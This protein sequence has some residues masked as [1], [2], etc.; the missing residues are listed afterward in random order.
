VLDDLFDDRGATICT[1]AIPGG[2]SGAMLCASATRPSFN[3]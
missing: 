2:K 3:K 1:V